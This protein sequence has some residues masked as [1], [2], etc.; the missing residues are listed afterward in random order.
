MNSEEILGRV[1]TEVF[2][3]LYQLTV[4]IAFIYFLYG[5]VRFI[6]GLSEPDKKNVGR[7]HLLWGIVGLFIIL[8]VGGMLRLFNDVLGGM[9]KF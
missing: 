7:E 8:S 3:P 5:V 4:G 9:F 1:I 2:S 6:M